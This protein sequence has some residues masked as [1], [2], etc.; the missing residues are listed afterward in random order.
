VAATAVGWSFFGD[1]PAFDVPALVSGPGVP[2]GVLAWFVGLGL[3][4]GV[5]A[6][7]VARSIYWFEDLFDAMPGNYYTRHISGMLL[8]GLILYGFMSLSGPWLGQASHYYVEGV[9]YATILDVLGGRQSAAGFLLL[10]AAA[11]LLVTCLTLGSGASGGVFSPSLFIGA[12]LGGCVGSGLSQLFPNLGLNPAHFA[13]AGMAALVGASTGAVV[14]ATVMIFEMTR[15][16]SVILPV[17]LTVVL[18]TAVR[19]RLSPSTIYTLKLLR[20]GHVVPQGLEAWR[21]EL[22]SKDVMTADFVLVSE[23]GARDENVVRE[24][25]LREQ[26]VVVTGEDHQVRRVIGVG[27][28][29]TAH[30]V[31]GPDDPLH[32]VLRTLEQAEARVALVVQVSAS[33]GRPEVVGVISERHIARVACAA[34]RLTG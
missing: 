15:A 5:A 8:V 16:Y 7:L 11:K 31:V 12:A 32:E 18:A 33:T 29:A 2:H 14:T 4:M 26:V 21:G 17:M 28:P 6:W 1:L 9:G 34:A 30:V 23:D 13:L 19:H 22:R 27:P 20:R 24:A 3:L 10:L 25:L